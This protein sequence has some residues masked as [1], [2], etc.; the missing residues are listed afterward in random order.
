MATISVPSIHAQSQGEGPLFVRA[1]VDNDR[2]YIGQQIAYVLR[3]YQRSDFTKKL[4]YIP[5]S[6]AG[7]WNSQPTQRDEY[8][9][10]IGPEQYRVIELRTLL[11]PSV[12]ETITID[13][14]SLRADAGLPGR[15][16]S[17]ESEP[18]D[19][20]VRPLPTGAPPGFVGAVGRFEISSEV[21][22]TIGTV[23]EPVLL[24]VK[25][26][27]DGNIEAL[28]DPTWPEFS[29]WRAIESPPTS[30]AEVIDGRVT[31]IR[32]YEL[33]LVPEGAGELTIPVIVYPHYD[34]EA[35]RY[36]QT[37]TVPIV[38]N[39][40][41]S[42]GAPPL[43]SDDAEAEPSASEAR[44]NKPVP[45]A[46][47]RRSGLTDSPI[48]WAAWTVPLFI[49]VGAAVW[50]RRVVSRE[51]ALAT[52]RQKNAL[53]NTRSALGRAAA[54]GIDTRIASADAVLSYM[55]DKFDAPLGGLTRDSLHLRLEEVGVP[56]DLAQQVEDTLAAGEVARYSP[57]PA[58]TGRT[59]DLVEQITQ[60][61]TDLE[62]A[63]GE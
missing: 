63:F 55:S 52:F 30:E 62:E 56:P 37:A 51:A 13:P 54:D 23:N 61:L 48:F 32:T 24:T 27:G 25:V 58:G 22:A 12:V 31:G 43:V 2:P 28:P 46:L 41:G 59:E 5:P 4:R 39:I 35:E 6:F 50:R 45:T 3:I 57:V 14:A 1:S 26:T 11:F 7:L 19:V 17:L 21:N 8:T 49:I 47:G 10:T 9:E 42:D 60:L 20:W 18:L 44:R 15:S 40:V 16:D 36:V 34:P 38:V 53:R 29:G 33:G